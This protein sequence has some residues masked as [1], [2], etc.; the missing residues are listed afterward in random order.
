MAV[1]TTRNCANGR[2]HPVRSKALQALPIPVSID[3]DSSDADL[4]PEEYGACAESTQPAACGGEESE[5]RAPM[6]PES[7][8]ES[9]VEAASDTTSADDATAQNES[10]SDSDGDEAESVTEEDL[11]GADV[12]GKSDAATNSIQIALKDVVTDAIQAETIEGAEHSSDNQSASQRGNGEPLSP[13]NSNPGVATDFPSNLRKLDRRSERRQAGPNERAC[14]P[15]RNA[16][17]R[18]HIWGIECSP[19]RCRQMPIE[20]L[21]RQGP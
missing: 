15:C 20:R 21:A 17:C 14:S 2:R 3:D 16:D 11:S 1:R 19:A 5:I 4:P 9:S 12:A 18:R 10:E 13:G 7:L 6:N 8:D